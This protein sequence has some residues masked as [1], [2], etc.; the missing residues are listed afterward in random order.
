MAVT[1]T[2]KQQDGPTSLSQQEAEKNL[3]HFFNRLNKKTFGNAA[4]IY[5]KK[6]RAFPVLERS[7]G[8]RWHFHL[9]M[10]KPFEELSE[11]MN[12]IWDCWSTTRWATAKL[13]PSQSTMLQVGYPISPRTSQLMAGTS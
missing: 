10:E 7:A 12:C 5:G 9:A 8:N 6:I 11:S 13:T 3:R 1:L 4:A 2:L